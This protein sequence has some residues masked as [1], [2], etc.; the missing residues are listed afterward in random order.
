LNNFKTDNGSK[1]LVYLAADATGNV[2]ISL[3]DLKGVNGNY[4][5]TIPKNTNFEKYIRVDICVLIFQ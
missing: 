3:G 4:I 5:Y 2:F 1:L